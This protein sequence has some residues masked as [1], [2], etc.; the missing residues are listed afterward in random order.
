[1]ERSEGELMPA[2]KKP[3][4]AKRLDDLENRMEDVDAS[5][6][7]LKRDVGLVDK[8]VQSLLK[9]VKHLKDA[10]IDRTKQWRKVRKGHSNRMSSLSDRLDKL[11]RASSPIY[12]FEGSRLL[13]CG[14]QGWKI[15]KAAHAHECASLTCLCL[16]PSYS[17][18]I[19]EYSQ[20]VD[21]WDYEENH[22]RYHRGC[23]PYLNPNKEVKGKVQAP[24]P[25][26][27][28]HAGQIVNV[29]VE[30]EPTFKKGCYFD[31][32]RGCKLVRSTAGLVLIVALAVG[33]VLWM[34]FSNPTPPVVI[35]SSLLEGLAVIT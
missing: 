28:S 13:S 25:E 20:Y 26:R 29:I 22:T 3:S 23:N 17:R 16:S 35:P 33:A 1:M 27:R 5:V 31:G 12:G 15:R 34:A 9:S 10:A 2:K 6:D 24:K 18:V 32:E 11:E 21:T 14:L 4:T 8:D 30:G 19:P 7:T